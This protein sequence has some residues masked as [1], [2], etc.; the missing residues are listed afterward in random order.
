MTTEIVAYQSTEAV[1]ADLT[2]RYAKVVFDVAKPDGMRDA[3]SAYK[4]INTHSITLE[5]ARVKEK[6]DSLTYGRKVDAE[7]KRIADKLD[8]LRLPIKG[9]IETET[10]REERER[11]EK[12]RVETERV[13]AELA[14]AKAAEEKRMAAERA[15]I[16]GDL[17][18]LAQAQVAANAKIE[19]E[20]RASRE[21]IEAE[22]RA[23]RLEREEADRVSRQ[24][25]EAEEAKAK[26]LRD[27]EDARL[28][29]ERDKLE[30]ERR[31]VEEAQRK[32]REAAEAKAKAEREAEE[33]KQR[34]IQRLANE[35]NDGYEMLAAF[36]RRFGKREEFKAVTKAI[37]PY[38][39]AP[40]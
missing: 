17:L 22:Q 4:E 37:G 30:A 21:K 10:K 34:E 20:A 28:K 26:K 31:A 40:V 27:E 25:R 36:V 24:V 32:E 23:A 6:A 2:A 9:M 8:A 39:K 7:A 29:S 15:K 35:L 11:E 38:L 13:A 16:A 19:A 1:V 14:A 3:K 18:A 33:A 12:I 5:A